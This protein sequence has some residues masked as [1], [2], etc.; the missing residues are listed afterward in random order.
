VLVVEA[1]DL[2]L[3]PASRSTDVLDEEARSARAA[4]L[5]DP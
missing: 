3:K 2:V 4:P 1:D 5:V